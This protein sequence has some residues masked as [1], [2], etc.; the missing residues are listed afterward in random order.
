MFYTSHDDEYNALHSNAILTRLLN[1]KF[2]FVVL[3]DPSLLHNIYEYTHAHS[4][5]HWHRSQR[6]A[7]A[8]HIAIAI[9]FLFAVCQSEE[10]HCCKQFNSQV[11]S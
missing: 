2:R 9:P 8:T 6:A 3:T 7:L 4:P 1:A 10:S 11:K 5:F